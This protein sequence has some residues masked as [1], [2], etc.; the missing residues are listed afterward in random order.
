ME[1]QMPHVWNFFCGVKTKNNNHWCRT[2]FGLCATVAA[3]SVMEILNWE[4]RQNRAKPYTL[5]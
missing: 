1:N 2:G 4:H 3:K 5:W